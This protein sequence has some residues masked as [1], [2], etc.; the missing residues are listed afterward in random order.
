MSNNGQTH[1]NTHGL[2]LTHPGSEYTREEWEWIQTITTWMKEN[3]VRFPSFSQVLAV[4]KS[5]GYRRAF[6][7]RR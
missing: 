4:F 3:K 1:P 6:P 5:M 2:L 7:T